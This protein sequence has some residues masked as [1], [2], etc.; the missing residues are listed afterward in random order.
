MKRHISGFLYISRDIFREMWQAEK[1]F[2]YGTH[3]VVIAMKWEECCR[4]LITIGITKLNLLALKKLLTTTVMLTWNFCL[5]LVKMPSWSEGEIHANLLYS[6]NLLLLSWATFFSF[7][8]SS[9]SSSSKAVKEDHIREEKSALLR[10][11]HNQSHINHTPTD[12]LFFLMKFN[13]WMKKMSINF[14]LS[15]LF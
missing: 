7:F 15:T 5:S 3:T 4:M 13:K 9:S 11:T 12:F 8:S 2:V 1:S 6:I 14:S 10:L